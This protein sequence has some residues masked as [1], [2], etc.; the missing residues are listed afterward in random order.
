MNAD[1]DPATQINA[2]PCGSGSETVAGGERFVLIRHHFF[3]FKLSVAPV[4]N[5]RMSCLACKN[6]LVLDLEKKDAL[7]KFQFFLFQLAIY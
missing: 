4:I 2:D 6:K 3:I 1:L 7:E 5:P